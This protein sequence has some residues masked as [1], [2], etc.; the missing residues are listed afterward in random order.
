HLCAGQRL[1]DTQVGCGRALVIGVPGFRDPRAA[2]L[3]AGG[4]APQPQRVRAQPQSRVEA[5]LLVV[6]EV[7]VA[8]AMPR[9]RCLT[10][11]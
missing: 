7:L 2:H 1:A 6:D 9:M 11:V 8:D 3:T 4:I 10:G 5:Q